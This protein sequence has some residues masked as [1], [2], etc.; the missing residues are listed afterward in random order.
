[1]ILNLQ[2]YFN[3]RVK[4]IDS[5]DLVDD[6]FTELDDKVHILVYY[7]NYDKYINNSDSF[8]FTINMEPFPDQ[9]LITKDSIYSNYKQHLINFVKQLVQI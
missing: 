6:E 3:D 7:M 9:N 4:C 2:K 1:M 5:S 8:I